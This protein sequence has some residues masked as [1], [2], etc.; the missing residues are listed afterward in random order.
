M[1]SNLHIIPAPS[2]VADLL[3]HHRHHPIGIPQLT[4]HEL[5]GWGIALPLDGWYS[6]KRWAA[7]VLP[8]WIE[9]HQRAVAE[10][11]ASPWTDMGAGTNAS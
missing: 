1:T 4:Q 2:G 11:T 7:D 9:H 10:L 3:W 6:S 8:L 5:G